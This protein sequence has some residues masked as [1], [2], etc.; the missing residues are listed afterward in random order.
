[1]VYQV[2]LNTPWPSSHDSSW[3]RALGGIHMCRG[4]WGGGAVRG[5][6]VFGGEEGMV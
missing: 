5:V 2:F 1:M 3:K 6:E 4:S